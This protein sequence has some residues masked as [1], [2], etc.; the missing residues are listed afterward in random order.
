MP[1]TQQAL[2]EGPF[3]TK[4]P[5]NPIFCHEEFLEK[6]EASRNQPA[7]KR[8]SLLIRNLA[9][10]MSRQHFKATHGVN[11]GWR[12]SRLG[13]AGGSHHY[14]WWAPRSA[15]PLRGAGGFEQAPEG[16]IFLRDIR[17]HDDH[18]PLSPNSLETHYLPI[19]VHEMRMET[20][21]AAP[22]TQ[23]QSRF[24]T[25]RQ[26][27]RI[28]KGHPGTGKTTALLHAADECGAQ[29]V[30]YL[31]Y[32]RDLANLA[33]EY[34][35]RF[36]SGTRQFAVLTFDAFIR[37]MAGSDPAQV[38]PADLKSRLRGDL[39]P[40]ARFLG[41]W[42][43]H[44]PALWDEM[45][46]HLVGSALPR[47]AGRF[48]ACKSP[49]VGD[50]EYRLRRLRYL[51]DGAV[52]AV[53]DVAAR[54]ER[55]EGTLAARY[56][57]ELDLA[58]RAA[59]T[60][61]SP[62]PAAAARFPDAD[63]ICVDECQDLTPLEA[64]VTIELA[65]LLS[66]RRRRTIPVFFAG[67]EAQT[68]RPTDFE[69]GWM[70]DLLHSRLGTPTEFKL[71]SNLRSPKT[72]ATLVN[73]VWDLYGR[74][75][76]RDRPSGTGYAEIEDDATDQ[77]HY[78]TATPGE[79]LNSCLET[80]TAREG[81][82]VVTYDEGLLQKLPPALRP[83]ILTAREVKGLDFHT[84]CLVNAGQQLEKISRA[85]RDFSFATID[86]ESLR[87]RLMIDELRVGISRPADRLIWLD[88]APSADVVRTVT[89]FLDQYGAQHVAPSVPSALLK[90][91]EEE[92]LDLEE[93]VQRCQLDARQFLSVRPELAWSRAKQA[94]ALLG[95]KSNPNA[96]QDEA[97]RASA[98][99]TLAEICFCL[100]FRGI[101][102]APEL[103][104]PDLFAESSKAM[105]PS[106]VS[107]LIRE[108]GVAVRSAD[109]QSKLTALG[110]VAQDFAR[111]SG[112]TPA[113]LLNEITPK[114]TGWLEQLEAALPIGDNPVT[115]AKIMPPFYRALN[116]P[117][118]EERSAKLLDKS[119]RTLLKAKRHHD[120]LGILKTLEKR[121]PELE[122]ECLEAT[123]EL[124]TAGDLYRSIGK[125]RE[126]LACYRAAP[127]FD[128]AAAMIRELPDHA[129]AQ[130]YDWLMRLRAIL[131][132]RPEN[133][134]KVMT[135]PE[136]KLLEQL[137]EQ[138]LGVQRKPKAPRKAAAKKAVAKRASLPKPAKRASR[139]LPPEDDWF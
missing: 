111:C 91:L 137:L 79:E 39:A 113:W 110:N 128:A 32:S 130:S 60:L 136:K 38:N 16:S 13:G 15:A 134:N 29:K 17:H 118:A 36:C 53:L 25:A 11:Q 127:D 98:H 112:Q 59:S 94:V 55:G 83:S 47:D 2:M 67:D 57:P 56:F 87:R 106:G 21:G 122:A 35:D 22:W 45:H 46:A 27:V 103:G 78:C 81:L 34:F 95:E 54:L 10:D 9:V 115:L 120:A 90:A 84:V 8:A 96:V 61:V 108:I 40:F 139:R 125:L 93:R 88:V 116:L 14:A 70:N 77:V 42:T 105:G 44:I 65:A 126:A 18:S 1:S 7:G 19:S 31:T 49:R 86:I 12:R 63:C 85:A 30:L 64:F 89:S 114:I 138:G 82:A 97:L 43:D 101:H 3:E 92:Q 75:E 132:Q 52:S 41:P 4:R 102:L 109:Q 76:K 58:W 104:R 23:Q 119:V 100:G 51:G 50:K 24:A 99:E 6:L 107:Q 26:A 66:T 73:H 129:A 33:R 135:A 48:S 68:V 121:R 124:K 28:L 72:I 123:G 117:D 133:F 37:Q 69:W 20:F 5:A 131:E 71:S 62:A 80:L 74:L